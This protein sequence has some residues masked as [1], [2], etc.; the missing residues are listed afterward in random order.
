MKFEV[1]GGV[2]SEFGFG[3]IDNWVIELNVII[4]YVVLVMDY[5]YSMVHSE[6]NFGSEFRAIT[7]CSDIDIGYWGLR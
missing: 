5:G 7:V 1:W 3:Y 6:T 2:F 4:D